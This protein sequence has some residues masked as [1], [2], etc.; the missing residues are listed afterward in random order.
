MNERPEDD[1]PIESLRAID[2]PPTDV[3]LREDVK[4]LGALVGEILAEQVSP[5]FLADVEALRVA[6]IRRREAGAPIEALSDRLHGLPLDRAELLTTQL[7]VAGDPG[8]ERDGLWRRMSEVDRA[9]VTVP[10]VPG[11]DGLRASFP[12]AVQA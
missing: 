7:Y 8:N 2:L 9:A 6:A 5:D 3:L 11:N 10:F 12:I 4:R 1:T